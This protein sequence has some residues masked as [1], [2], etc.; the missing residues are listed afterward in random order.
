M[1]NIDGDGADV[2]ITRCIA[3]EL[4]NLSFERYPRIEDA[5]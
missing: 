3:S 4:Y 5:T 1:D 2:V